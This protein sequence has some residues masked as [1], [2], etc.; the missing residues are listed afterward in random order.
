[1]VVLLRFGRSSGPRLILSVGGIAS[2]SH[3]VGLTLRGIVIFLPAT[4]DLP[5]KYYLIS[6]NR[7]PR[8]A[9]ITDGALSTIV[10]E[11]WLSMISSM[12]HPIDNRFLLSNFL[13][14]L[15]EYTLSL[16]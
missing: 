16:S 3:G 1:M 7:F 4:G 10:V 13:R 2:G 11:L 6:S 9:S 5:P 8:F 14:S 15:N 12:I